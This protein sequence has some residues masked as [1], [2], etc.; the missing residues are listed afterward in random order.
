MGTTLGWTS[1]AGPMLQNNQYPFHV[2]DENVS[3]IAALMPLAALFG[4]PFTAVLIDKLGR[5]NM[6]LLMTIPTLF[7]WL[8][9]I[10]AKSVSEVS[11][12]IFNT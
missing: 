11:I 7:G 5:K 4:C 12:Y 9:I 1:P 2:T 6:M 10:F 3:W 8:M